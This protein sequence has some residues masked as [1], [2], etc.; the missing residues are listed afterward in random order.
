MIIQGRGLRAEDIGLIQ[1]L[2][3]EHRDWG[4]TRHSQELGCRW[5]WRNAGDRIKHMAARTLLL[6]LERGGHM[7]PPERR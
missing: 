7:R 2:S 4:R 6:K 3:A 5:D 1:G